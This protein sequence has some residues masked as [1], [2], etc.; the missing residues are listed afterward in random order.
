M[1]AASMVAAAEEAVKAATAVEA[2][3]ASE[4]AEGV[5]GETVGVLTAMAVAMG[6]LEVASSS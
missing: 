4:A 3:K 2:A 5:A 6:A 1:C